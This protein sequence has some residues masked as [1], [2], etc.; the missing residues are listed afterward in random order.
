MDLVTYTYLIGFLNYHGLI[1]THLNEY[2]RSRVIQ[3][4]IFA[5]KFSEII[6]GEEWN[7]R[8]NL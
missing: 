6:A 1:S 4:E 8:K 7:I 3:E 2:A 5:K